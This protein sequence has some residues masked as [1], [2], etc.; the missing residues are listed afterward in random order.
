MRVSGKIVKN[1]TINYVLEVRKKGRKGRMN[2]QKN[3][4]EGRREPPNNETNNYITCLYVN[5]HI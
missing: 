3:R 1:H 5:V 4:W 2:K